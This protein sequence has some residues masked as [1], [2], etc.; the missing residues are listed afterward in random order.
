MRTGSPQFNNQLYGAADPVGVAGEWLTASL[1]TN[2]HTYEVAPVFTLMEN[3]VLAKFA[4]VVGGAFVAQTP[5][6]EEEAAGRN[7][8]GG[9]EA[10]AHEG[11]L[12][13][14]GS[15]A[16]MYGMQLARHRKCP[17]TKA[18]GNAAAPGP[19]V[20]FTSAEAHYSY[21]KVT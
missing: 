10:A 12:V 18:R 15:I 11:L 16:N 5:E 21:L 2:V 19:L 7:G 4:A 6:E 17:A 1:N 20:A 14:G 3:A 9:G 8:G 13:P